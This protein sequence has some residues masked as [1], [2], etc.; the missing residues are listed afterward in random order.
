[1]YILGPYFPPMLYVN[2]I[3]QNLCPLTVVATARA[4]G[5]ENGI[6]MLE[7]QMPAISQNTSLKLVCYLSG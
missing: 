3:V 5:L 6:K 7:S 4:L 2:N 1:M